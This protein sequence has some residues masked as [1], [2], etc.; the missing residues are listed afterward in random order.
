MCFLCF[1]YDALVVAFD[2]EAET[3]E[4]SDQDYNADANK[5]VGYNPERKTLGECL[6]A[7]SSICKL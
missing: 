6:L 3:E 2:E 4:A 5:L 7:G 1:A